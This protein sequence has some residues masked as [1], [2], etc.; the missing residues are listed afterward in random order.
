MKH[1]FKLAI[2]GCL[3]FALVACKYDP[4]EGFDIHSPQAVITND[5]IEASKGS[6]VSL[7]A[8]LSDESGLLSCKLDYSEWNVLQ[9][10]KLDESGY[11]KTYEFTANIVIPDDAKESWLEDYQKNDGTV[12][13]ITQTYHKISLTFYD[14][15]K[16]MNV[17]NFYI[18]VLP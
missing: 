11:P 4:N 13:N 18:K 14:T 17:V 15:V 12:F 8:T 6:T 5:T 16:N 9:E 10:I 2:I 3:G 7:K 1:I